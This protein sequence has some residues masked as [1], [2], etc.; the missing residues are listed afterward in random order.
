MTDAR[1]QV[2]ITFLSRVWFILSILS[3]SALLMNG[4]FFVE[5]DIYLTDSYLLRPEIAVLGC[6]FRA[7]A[8]MAPV[9]LVHPG[10]PS[11]GRSRG[12]AAFRFP[13]KLHY[14]RHDRVTSFVPSFRGGG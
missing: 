5:R 6:G 10:R 13:L 8:T 11:R 14:W 3:L 9:G 4:P 1:A 7:E 12:R 2:R